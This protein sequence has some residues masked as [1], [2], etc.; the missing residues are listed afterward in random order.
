MNV[1]YIFGL[2]RNAELLKASEDMTFA[3]NEMN[4]NVDT[5]SN[6]VDK[7]KTDI[8][9]K[10][11]HE[12]TMNE[13]IEDYESQINQLKA[14]IKEKEEIIE[15]YRKDEEAKYVV[16]TSPVKEQRNSFVAS[17]NRSTEFDNTHDLKGRMSNMIFDSIKENEDLRENLIK[18]KDELS[19]VS[20]VFEQHKEKAQD[21]EEQLESYKTHYLSLEKEKSMSDKK[22]KN[23]RFKNESLVKDIGSKKKEIEDLE[24]KNSKL[25]RKITS[26]EDQLRHYEII[27]KSQDELKEKL[28]QSY[29]SNLSRMSTSL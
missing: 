10:E 27:I 14:E 18:H 20:Q 25:N 23:F 17:I 9:R 1:L 28:S 15:D 2:E 21:I 4:I 16:R 7:L 29:N 19:R 3:I 22:L 12:Q 13:Y 8:K 6:E 5:L 24:V 11:R 26:L